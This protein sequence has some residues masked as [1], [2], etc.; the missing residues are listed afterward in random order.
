MKLASDD[1]FKCLRVKT[2]KMKQFKGFSLYQACTIPVDNTPAHNN[3]RQKWVG[4]TGFA[5]NGISLW[6]LVAGTNQRQPYSRTQADTPFGCIHF[7][8]RVSCVWVV[9]VFVWSWIL[10]FWLLVFLQLAQQS[11]LEWIFEDFLAFVLPVSWR[12]S[13]TFNGTKMLHGTSSHF[14]EQNWRIR[15]WYQNGTWYQTG[16]L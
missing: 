16:T 4:G 7:G 2:C 12:E 5:A 11:Q 1:R 14:L 15:K 9:W 10:T 13:N 3:W 6:F 8:I